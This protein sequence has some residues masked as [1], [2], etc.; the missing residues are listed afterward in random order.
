MTDR[1]GT[2]WAKVLEELGG[3]DPPEGL[4]E[5]IGELALWGD[6][7]HLTGRERMPEAI[8]AQV[9]DSLVMLDLAGEGKTAA[10]I[11][12]GAGF[13]GLVWKLA[14][15]GLEITLFERKERLASF[16]ERTASVLGLGGIAVRAEDASNI[17]HG[18]E[19]DIVTSKAAGRLGEILPLVS[20]MLGPGGI[21]VTAKGDG[22]ERELEDAPFALVASAPLGGGRGVAIALRRT[23]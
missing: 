9:S 10:D 6:R 11:G 1:T 16:L 15:P 19:Y 14:R 2:I 5:Y 13:P 23:D 21:Y 17:V 8:A 7:I 4:R 18:E 22:W 20:A 12:S 3:A